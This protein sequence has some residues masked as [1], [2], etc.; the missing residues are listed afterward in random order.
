MSSHLPPHLKRLED[1]AIYVFR[2]VVAE[3]EKPVMLFSI[4]K[5][6]ACMLRVAQKAFRPGKIPFPLIH[7][8]TTFKFP[9]MY[10]YRDR[11]AKELGVELI[12]Y[13]NEEALAQFGTDPANWTCAQCADL[14]KTRALVQALKHY[15][16]DAAFG[17]ARRDEERSRAKERVLSFRDRNQ[18]WDPKNQRPELWRLYNTC[19]NPGEGFR[20]F[21]LSDWTELNIWEY[22]RLENVPI[23]PL[24]FAAERKVVK[25]DG[26]YLQVGP[27]LSPRAGEVV[28]TRKVRYRSIGCQLCTGCVE[29]DCSSLDDIVAEIAAARNSE[30]NT[31]AVD[32]DR[33]D[34]SMEDKK[35][36]GY[37]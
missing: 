3:C 28:E 6:S 21:P 14:L 17:G 5:D 9:E 36:E 24:Y 33:G 2:E 37:F 25:R 31:R 20:V 4:G 11:M 13:R 32:R 23:V 16:F 27:A 30:R 22:I 18:V 19:H 15:G 10:A 35:R 12:I 1:D 34:G 26:M 8:D 29:S 7:V